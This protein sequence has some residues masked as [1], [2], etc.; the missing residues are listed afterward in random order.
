MTT[1]V[2]N[3]GMMLGRVGTSAGQYA[4]LWVIKLVDLWQGLNSFITLNS[5]IMGEFI[6]EESEQMSIDLM[7]IFFEHTCD[8]EDERDCN[9]MTHLILAEIRESNAPAWVAEE[10]EK[11]L[12]CRECW[13]ALAKRAVV[14]PGFMA[15]DIF[16]KKSRGYEPVNR[17]NPVKA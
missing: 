7:G 9:I 17:T 6:E 2:S 8:A 10:L 14:Y 11:K 4:A 12:N 3:S 5:Y 1:E 15:P 16:L 13:N